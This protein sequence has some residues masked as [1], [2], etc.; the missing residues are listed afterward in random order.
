MLWRFIKWRRN[1]SQGRV[2]LEQA[3]EPATPLSGFLVS[4]ILFASFST[5]IVS[6][7]TSMFTPSRQAILQ[8]Y[9]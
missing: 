6:F 8:L 5:S 2:R 3:V 1:T 7:S 9:I 4:W